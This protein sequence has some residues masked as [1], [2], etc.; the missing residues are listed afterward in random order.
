MSCSSIFGQKLVRGEK[1]QKIGLTT[2]RLQ[3]QVIG[4]KTPGKENC[5]FEISKIEKSQNLEIFQPKISIS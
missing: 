3:N 2:Y 1:L 5:Y 4:L